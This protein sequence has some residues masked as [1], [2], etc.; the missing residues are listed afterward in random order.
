ML[1]TWGKVLARKRFASFLVL[2]G[3]DLRHWQWLPLTQYII[4][5]KQATKSGH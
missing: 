5:K 2:L 1:M 3:L 4:E